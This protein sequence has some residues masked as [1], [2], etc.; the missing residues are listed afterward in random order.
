MAGRVTAII[1]ARLESRRFPRKVLYPYRGKP[2]LFYVWDQISRVRK[3]DRLFIATD[4]DE[5]EKSALSFGAEVVR[6]SGKHKTGTDR[7]AEA[8]TKVDGDI[9]INIQADNFGLKARTLSGI[10]GK[11]KDDKSVQFATMANP[12]VSDNELFNPNVVKLVLSGDGHALWFSRFPIPYLRDAGK[13][14]HTRQFPFLAHIGIYFFRRKG[15]MEFSRW[16][17]SALEKAESL[18]QL[19][20][21]ENNRRI[22]VF[23]TMDTIVAVDTP[24]DLKN[25]KDLYKS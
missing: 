25:L 20:I 18:E 4:S 24:Q 7:I 12:I 11:I 2:L 16:R 21:L 10:I 1:P 9:I 8:V 17:R 3:I 6:T 14:K 22:R 5:I 15:L 19:R 23:K 13:Q